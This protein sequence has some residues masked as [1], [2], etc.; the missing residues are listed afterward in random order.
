MCSPKLFLLA[1][2]SVPFLMFS[3]PP[4]FTLLAASIS[5]FPTAAIKFS[6]FSS[7][8]FVAFVFNHSL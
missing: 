7:T 8:K 1:C 4:I 5:H 6:R 2:V 3:L